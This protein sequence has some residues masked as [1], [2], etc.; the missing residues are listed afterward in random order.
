ME[1]ALLRLTGNG[2]KIYSNHR[3]MVKIPS[4]LARLASMTGEEI[5]DTGWH[6]QHPQVDRQKDI[7]CVLATVC[8]GAGH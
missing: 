8:L 7:V 6:T 1:S 5:P 4:R 3:A 2:G